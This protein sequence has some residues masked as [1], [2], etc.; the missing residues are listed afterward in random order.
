M[1]VAGVLPFSSFLIA[2]I[3]PGN[4]LLVKNLNMP[5]LVK[6]PPFLSISKKK[7]VSPDWGVPPRSSAF[8]VYTAWCV[9]VF[10]QML[11]NN[12]LSH[13]FKFHTL[14]CCCLIGMF[15]SLFFFFLE[16]T[17]WWTSRYKPSFI[18]I[19]KDFSWA[20]SHSFFQAGS[21]YTHTH[22]QGG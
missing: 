12:S 14:F 6:I 9:H 1:Y 18:Q 16:T 5:D 7:P 2:Q 19:V 17:L 21:C 8:Y 10:P 4:I 20:D 11:P 3:I 15:L 22:T 13:Y